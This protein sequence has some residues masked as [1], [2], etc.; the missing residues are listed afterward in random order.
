ME[1]NFGIKVKDGKQ[2][3]QVLEKLRQNGEKTFDGFTVGGTWEYICFNEKMNVWSLCEP[4]LERYKQDYYITAE[5]FLLD[6]IEPQYE[7][8]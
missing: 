8:Y 7:V 1:R 2:K 3:D 4:G 6:K 5:E